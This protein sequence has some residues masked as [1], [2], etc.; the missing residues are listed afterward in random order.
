MLLSKTILPRAG[1]RVKKIGHVGEKTGDFFAE[2]IKISGG[3]Y[4]PPFKCRV[5]NREKKC[6]EVLCLKGL[7]GATPRRV[8]G[9]F[10]GEFFGDIFEVLGVNFSLHEKEG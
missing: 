4:D 1:T 9:E 8:F 7:R 6:L 5:P 2:K 10:F 3:Y